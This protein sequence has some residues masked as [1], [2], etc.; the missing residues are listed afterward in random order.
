MNRHTA[1]TAPDF[2]DA[3]LELAEANRIP[4]AELLET[5][6]GRYPEFAAQIT[7]FAV[8]LTIDMLLN[9]GQDQEIPAD[10]EEV[11]PMV[12]R[13]ISN[14]EN[15]L[16]R[17]KQE[18]DTSGETAGMAPETKTADP[19]ASMDRGNFRAFAAAIHANN[20][21]AMKI[22]DRQINPATIPKRYLEMIA[23]SLSISLS[24]L[25]EFLSLRTDRLTTGNQF[26]KADDKPNHN[27]QQSF[28]DAVSDSGMTDDQQSFLLGLK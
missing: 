17:R 8:E 13:A 3:I 11:S 28:D 21:F 18:T 27:L 19:F 16:F 5:V 22:R 10:L 15:E 7:E 20:L 2:Q 23:E 9:G 1:H 4:D 14:F 12:G 26:F 6:V 25:E 24:R